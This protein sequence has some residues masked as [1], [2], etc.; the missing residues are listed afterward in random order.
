M[1]DDSYNE[2]VNNK[3]EKISI[4][5][6]MKIDTEVKCFKGNSELKIAKFNS[7]GKN[8][9]KELPSIEELEFGVQKKDLCGPDDRIRIN[10][11]DEYPWRA[12]CRLIITRDDGRVAVGSGWFNG[13]GSVITAGH[14]VYS[15]ELKKWNKSI[16]VIPGKD[17]NHEPYGRFISTNFWSVNGWTNQGNSEYDYGAI[18]LADKIGNSIGYFG[19]RYDP[20]SVIKDKIIINSGYPADKNGTLVDTQW[21]MKGK[22]DRLSERKIYY[23]L[24]TYGGN[25]GS[26]VWLDDQIYQSICIHAYGGCSNSGTRI[27]SEAFANLMKWRTQGESSIIE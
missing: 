23:M 26:P 10:N 2:I 12:I 22:I 6:S 17:Y 24:D 8:D 19:F 4:K 7:D 13:P 3:G 16:I 11:A 27:N 18:I 5:N 14:C 9:I 25:S 21:H 1:S 20:D 15:N